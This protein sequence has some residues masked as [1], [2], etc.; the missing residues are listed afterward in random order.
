MSGTGSTGR[1]SVLAHDVFGTDGELGRLRE[2]GT[3]VA[4]CP[5][6]NAAL[7]SGIFPMRRHVEAGVRFALGTDVGGG[8]GFS[9]MREALQAHL[10]QRVAAEPM[11][12]SSEKMLYL[13]TLAGAEALDMA[14]ETG[15]FTVGKSADFV[16][17]EAGPGSVLAGVLAVTEEPAKMLGA[18]FTLAGPECI[19]EVRVAGELVHPR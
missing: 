6:S 1:R 4:H 5:S 19:R 7:G 12:V 18:I 17:L 16:Y 10:M 9:V 15:D 13:A 11:V 3:S 8:V 14:E 2:S